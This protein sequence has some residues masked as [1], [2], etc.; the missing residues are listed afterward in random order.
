VN[1]KQSIPKRLDRNGTLGD[2]VVSNE[3]I[4]EGW[5]NFLWAENL[6]VRDTSTVFLKGYQA[7]HR[8]FFKGKDKQ[9]V[10]RGRKR[11][12]DERTPSRGAGAG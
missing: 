5:R 2:S 12:C 10:V 8:T 9:N 6:R 4:L 3:S 7:L 11:P 1:L